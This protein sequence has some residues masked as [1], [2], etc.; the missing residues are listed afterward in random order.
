MYFIVVGSLQ[1]VGSS[2]AGGT[3]HEYRLAQKT[4]RAC[5]A[6]VTDMRTHSGVSF[7][8]P[9]NFMKQSV[10]CIV[11]TLVIVGSIHLL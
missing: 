3:D 11:L 5:G 2:I 4:L 9:I 10:I 7:L 1:G 8:E 6:E